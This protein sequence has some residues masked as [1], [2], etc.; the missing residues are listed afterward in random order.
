MNLYI[1]DPV[2]GCL[3]K[4]FSETHFHSFK[5]FEISSTQEMGH[6]ETDGNLKAQDQG[7][8]LGVVAVQF[9][10]IPEFLSWLFVQYGVSNCPAAKK[11]LFP[12]TNTGY[13]RFKIS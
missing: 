12:L 6:V 9:L 1:I 10:P 2:S 5:V 7:C 4:E 11:I 13:I 8:M 3:C